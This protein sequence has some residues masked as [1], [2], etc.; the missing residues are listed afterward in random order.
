M[1]D[2]EYSTRQKLVG[3]ITKTAARRVL[4]Y[5]KALDRIPACTGKNTEGDDVGD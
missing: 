1:Y 5:M 4:R 2:V 3:G